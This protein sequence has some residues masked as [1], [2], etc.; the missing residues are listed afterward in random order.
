VKAVRITAE[1]E[2][3]V[4]SCAAGGADRKRKGEVSA[5]GYSSG[6]SQSETSNP[7]PGDAVR[8]IVLSD[9]SYRAGQPARRIWLTFVIS[10]D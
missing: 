10:G 2:P 1:H 9:G 4:L 5:D 7:N 3:D 6:S 8:A